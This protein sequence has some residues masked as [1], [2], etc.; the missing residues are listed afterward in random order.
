MMTIRLRRNSVRKEKPSSPERETNT[1]WSLRHVCEQVASE[2]HSRI[3]GEIEVHC[4]QLAHKI[5]NRRSI[6]PLWIVLRMLR[7]P[8]QVDDD[9]LIHQPA[10]THQLFGVCL[11]Q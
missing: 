4:A 9:H 5:T 11:T 1:H 8:W 2:V 7:C 10:V 6:V 3:D